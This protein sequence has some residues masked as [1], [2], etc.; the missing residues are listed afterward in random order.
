VTELIDYDP[1]W[2]GEVAPR[3][4][5]WLRLAAALV[6]VVLAAGVALVLWADHYQP[7][8]IGGGSYGAGSQLTA[9]MDDSTD[10]D[11]QGTPTL[12]NALGTEFQVPAASGD[13]VEL[14]FTISNN[15]SQPVQI[16]SFGPQLGPGG[17]ITV[18][19]FESPSVDGGPALF[20]PFAPFTLGG[21]ASR[22]VVVALTFAKVCPSGRIPLFEKGGSMG[23]GSM[24][25]AYSYRGI[26][27][28]R[29]LSLNKIF[30]SLENA[31]LCF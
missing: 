5:W 17:N 22:S 18:G 31:P 21:H 28:V 24:A 11:F 16:R 6:V 20:Q 9:S 3:R 12:A 15:Q 25:L 27:H 23:F 8:A 4:G 30:F 2:S 7:L 10:F 29:N 19:R 14:L 1:T 13:T 26:R